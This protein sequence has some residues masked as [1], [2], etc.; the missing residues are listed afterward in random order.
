MI[1]IRAVAKKLNDQG[2][3]NTQ[4]HRGRRDFFIYLRMFSVLS[5][6]WI[7]GILTW[8]IP[9]NETTPIWLSKLQDIFVFL[10]VL[11]AGANGILIF[12]IFTFNKRIYRLY[13]TLFVAKMPWIQRNIVHPIKNWRLRRRKISAQSQMSKVTISTQRSYI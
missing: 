8:A 9:D 12:G 11:F 5:F 4:K 2:G 6:N 1:S 7:F 10:F 13:A 3:R